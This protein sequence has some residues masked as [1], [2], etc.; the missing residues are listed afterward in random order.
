MD[1]IYLFGA[2]LLS[3]GVPGDNATDI[4]RSEIIVSLLGRNFL[5]FSVVTL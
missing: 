3:D 1:C 4:Q 2:V 5:S